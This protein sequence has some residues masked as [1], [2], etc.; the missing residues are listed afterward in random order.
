MICFTEEEPQPKKENEW[1]SPKRVVKRRR[2]PSPKDNTQ[3]TDYSEKLYWVINI[4]TIEVD[5]PLYWKSEERDLTIFY[6]GDT[7]HNFI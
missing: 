3:W 5:V 6:N 1:S 2:K 7:V 4:L